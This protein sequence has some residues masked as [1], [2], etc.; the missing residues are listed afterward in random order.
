MRIDDAEI[1]LARVNPEAAKSDAYA[2][3]SAGQGGHPPPNLP[4]L[5]QIVQIV[6][7]ANRLGTP[8]QTGKE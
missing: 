3:S 2:E 5:L 1:L 6:R 4:R 8:A 7:G